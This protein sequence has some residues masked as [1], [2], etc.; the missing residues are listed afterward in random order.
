MVW[1]VC[2]EGVV[3]VSVPVCVVL[4]CTQCDMVGNCEHH[5]GSLLAPYQ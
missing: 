3:L 5:G 2:R 1:H 4:V